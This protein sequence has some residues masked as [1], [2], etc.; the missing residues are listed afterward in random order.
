MEK[1]T[2]HPGWYKGARIKTNTGKIIVVLSDGNYLSDGLSGLWHYQ[3]RWP[4][5]EVNV[6]TPQ[7]GDKPTE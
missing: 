4:S 3:V 6:R 2:N 5:G 7:M 1:F